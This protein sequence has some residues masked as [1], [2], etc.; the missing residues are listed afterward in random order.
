MQVLVFAILI[1]PTN[2]QKFFQKFIFLFIKKNHL[3]NE[4]FQKINFIKNSL[5]K[6]ELHKKKLREKFDFKNRSYKIKIKK[7][8][9][10]KF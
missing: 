3:K 9:K 7:L 10:I 1:K 5:N 4:K 2:K 6:Q 8:E